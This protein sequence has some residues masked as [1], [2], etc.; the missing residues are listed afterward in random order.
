[1]FVGSLRAMEALRPGLEA[2]LAGR[3]RVERTAYP[4]HGTGILDVIAAGQ[5]A[6]NAI[7]K[8]DED[9]DRELPF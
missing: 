3:A 4:A 9:S 1:M 6:E 7:E 5:L 2:G 8:A